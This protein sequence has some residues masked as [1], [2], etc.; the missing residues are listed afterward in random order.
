MLAEYGGWYKAAAVDRLARNLL[1]NRQQ[2]CNNICIEVSV[3]VIHWLTETLWLPVGEKQAVTDQSSPYIQLC[4]VLPSPISFQPFTCMLLSTSPFPDL[5]SRC[6]SLFVLF[7][8]GHVASVLRC[9]S[10][11]VQTAVNGDYIYCSPVF[12]HVRW[13]YVSI[14]VTVWL[15]D[16]L[17]RARVCL[18]VCLQ[19]D[20]DDYTA[21]F[22]RSLSAP[23]QEWSGRHHRRICVQTTAERKLSSAHS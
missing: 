8:C 12:W 9:L 7:L 20:S 22:G 16:W 2:F 11:L 4:F 3:L 19:P 14:W 1:C 15:C 21:Q 10:L 23:G 18:L 13:I 6:A 5:S 17:K